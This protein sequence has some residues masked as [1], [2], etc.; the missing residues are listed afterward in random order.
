MFQVSMREVVLNQTTH[1]RVESKSN[2]SL[3]HTFRGIPRG[4]KYEITVAT[5]AKGATPANITAAANPLP[6][7]RLMSIY[8]EKNGSYVVVW[9]EVKDMTSEK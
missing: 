1:V 4:A 9:K 6:A 7:P 2:S 3:V 8:P 5:D